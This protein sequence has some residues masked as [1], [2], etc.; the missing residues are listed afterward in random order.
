MGTTEQIFKSLSEAEQEEL[1]TSFHILN[2]LDFAQNL[3]ARPFPDSLKA[4][5]LAAKVGMKPAEQ[6]DLLQKSLEH[7]VDGFWNR[8]SDSRVR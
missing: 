6:A 8:L 1:F 4:E 3:H 7:A 5:F 2:S